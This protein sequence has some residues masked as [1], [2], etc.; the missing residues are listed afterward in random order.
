MTDRL[1]ACDGDGERV[2]GGHPPQLGEMEA[3]SSNVA[4][5]VVCN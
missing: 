4:R 2:E 5:F 1:R 3:S